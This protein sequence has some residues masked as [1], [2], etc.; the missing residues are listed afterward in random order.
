MLLILINPQS[1]LKAAPQVFKKVVR[2]QLKVDFEVHETAA[3]HHANDLIKN[4][5]VM[6]PQT[7]EIMIL[8]GKI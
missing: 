3:Q 1:G 4:H 8:G 6:Y 7:S 5:F 2:P